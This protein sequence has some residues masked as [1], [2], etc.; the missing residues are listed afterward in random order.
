M[1]GRTLCPRLFVSPS[2]EPFRREPGGGQCPLSTWF[3]GAD[4]DHDGTLSRA[5]FQADAARFFRVLDRDADGILDAT[6]VSA[7]SARCSQRSAA[8]GTRRWLNLT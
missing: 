5:E 3:S 7:T 8:A 1:S 6:E 2:G 4:A